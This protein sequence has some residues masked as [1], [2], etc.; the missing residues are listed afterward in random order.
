[1]LNVIFVYY[2]IPVDKRFWIG[3]SESHL[4]YSWNLTTTS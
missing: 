1:M 4:L 2:S 3:S